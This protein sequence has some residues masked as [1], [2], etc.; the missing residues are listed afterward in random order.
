MNPETTELCVRLLCDNVVHGDNSQALKRAGDD[1]QALGAHFRTV[2]QSSRTY[3]DAM[4]E[5]L[6]NDA[7]ERVPSRAAHAE[8]FARAMAEFATALHALTELEIAGTLAQL[9]RG[10]D[11]AQDRD[12]GWVAI[13]AHTWLLEMAPF[14]NDHENLGS[15]IL[16][17]QDYLK[18][19]AFFQCDMLAAAR[20]V[21]KMANEESGDRQNMLLHL[22]TI[23]GLAR[24]L[25][26]W[27]G[28]LFDEAA[29]RERDHKLGR[30]FSS[31]FNV[32][33]DDDEHAAA[34]AASAASAA[35][36]AAEPARF[37]PARTTANLRAVLDDQEMR[38]ELSQMT[39]KI[40]MRLNP[41]LNASDTSAFVDRML[42]K[43]S[44]FL[45][46][47]VLARA[48]QSMGSPAEIAAMMR[49]GRG[50]NAS[51]LSAVMSSMADGGLN[52]A[53]RRALQRRGRR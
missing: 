45:N 18:G 23:Y 14:I 52:R 48:A 22:Q 12:I 35:A 19:D 33:A 24:R 50:G 8:L 44:K 46:P 11:V 49:G 37:D 7:D 31:A 4:P 36:S 25:F 13:S 43:G 42:D 51:A 47:E 29:L 3:Q 21:L 53:Q 20:G 16:V 41:S 5:E 28:M 15:C 17:I 27:E 38:S 39:R 34:P 9:W 40:A 26:L 1:V 10:L 32:V 6:R 2:L 30:A